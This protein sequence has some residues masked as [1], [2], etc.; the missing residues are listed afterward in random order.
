MKSLRIE[1]QFFSYKFSVLNFAITALKYTRMHHFEAIF[2]KFPGG[3]PPDSH[4]REGVTP[5]PTLP[6]LAL[7]AS[8]KPS[9]SNLCA[10]AVFYR[11]PEEKKL[12]TPASPLEMTVWSLFTISR[13]ILLYF[14]R[15]IRK[16]DG[17]GHRQFNHRSYVVV[18]HL[19]DRIVGP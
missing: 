15:S 16:W 17:R 9:A 4:L 10:P 14:P 18:F 5:S 7:R 19:T 8:V 3:D 1:A 13:G 2:Q 12:D 11:A 6:L